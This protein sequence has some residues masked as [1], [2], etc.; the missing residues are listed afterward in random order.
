MTSV[1][2]TQLLL[3][4]LILTKVPNCI[5]FIHGLNRYESPEAALRACKQWAESAG[6]YTV[7]RTGLWI[8]YTLL[9]VRLCRREGDSYVGLRSLWMQQKRSVKN[10]MR[11][12]AFNLIMSLVPR[13]LGSVGALDVTSGRSLF[14]C[15][16]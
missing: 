16:K 2:M 9:P 1:R 14:P 4:A 8:R 13:I 6:Q 15:R 11:R 10:Q 3:G 5:S 12:R 7:K